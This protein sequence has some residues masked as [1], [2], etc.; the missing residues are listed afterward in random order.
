[1]IVQRLTV[2][3]KKGC[4]DDVLALLKADRKRTGIDYRIYAI[5]IGTYDQISLEIESENLADYEKGWAEWGSTPEAAAFMEK[6][7][8]LTKTGGTNE[9]WTL[10]E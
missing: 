3:V 8:E 5:N 2:N 6:W 9:I 1:M 4:M 7:L 10:V